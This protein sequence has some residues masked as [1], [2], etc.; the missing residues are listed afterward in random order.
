MAKNISN[1]DAKH[2][3]KNGVKVIDIRDKKDFQASHIPGSFNIDID[4]LNRIKDFI[5]SQH[6][7][8]IVICSHGIRSIAVAE[9]LTELG[10]TNVFNLLNGYDN[11]KKS[12]H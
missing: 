5:Y 3:I 1:Q 4:E 10:Y 9:K 7:N 6:E 12:G 2:L 11:Y 8:I